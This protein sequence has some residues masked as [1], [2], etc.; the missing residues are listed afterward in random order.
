[1]CSD[2]DSW[3]LAYQQNC[4]GV[5][6]LVVGTKT[7]ENAASGATWSYS[8]LIVLFILFDTMGIL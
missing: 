6:S 8:G 3:G 7:E 1:M 4:T 2:E 5:E